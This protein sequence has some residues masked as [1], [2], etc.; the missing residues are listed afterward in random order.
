[1]F[2]KEEKAPSSEA[3]H[4][5]VARGSR[6]RETKPIGRSRSWMRRMR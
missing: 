6:S 1:L 2:G 5:E 3:F 4:S